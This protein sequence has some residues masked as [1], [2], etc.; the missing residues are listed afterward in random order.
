MAVNPRELSAAHQPSRG[1]ARALGAG[2]DEWRWLP[3]QCHQ[4]IPAAG[5]G[6]PSQGAPTGKGSC[7]GRFP[8]A[9]PG[10]VLVCQCMAWVPRPGHPWWVDTGVTIPAR[11]DSLMCKCFDLPGIN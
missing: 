3:Q 5:R 4:L 8:F 10:K 7:V 9:G 6:E 11:H 2:Q 1:T